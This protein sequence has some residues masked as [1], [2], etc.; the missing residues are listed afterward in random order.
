[1]ILYKFLLF[2]V[3]MNFGNVYKGYCD[4]LGGY[5][6]LKKVKKIVQKSRETSIYSRLQYCAINFRISEAAK[7]SEV[8][9]TLATYLQIRSK[10]YSSVFNK[11][12]IKFTRFFFYFF[13][14]L[15]LGIQVSS[16]IISAEI[17]QGRKLFKGGNY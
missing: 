1:M 3:A 9:M 17:I 10:N 6:D 15:Q 8:N 14:L 13:A 7:T 4:I 16:Y 12:F 5:N 2:E 11:D